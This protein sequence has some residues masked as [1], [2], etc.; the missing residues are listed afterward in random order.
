[1]GLLN[2]NGNISGNDKL[3]LAIVRKGE[4]QLVVRAIKTSAIRFF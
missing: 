3:L 4:R 2:A 1:M